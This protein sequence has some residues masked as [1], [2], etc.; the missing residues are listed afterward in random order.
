MKKVLCV[1]DSLTFGS[2]GYSYVRF[3]GGVEAV[4]RGLNGDCLLGMERRLRQILSSRLYKDI[5]LIVFWGGTNDVF[6]PALK[7][8]SCFW[9]ISNTLRPKLFGYRYCDTEEE[10]HAV[11]ERIIRLVLGENKKLLLM[12]LP[13]TE[14]G[15]VR[16]NSTLQA[17][18]RS[19]RELAEKYSLEF[20]DVYKL[21]D[22]MR[23]PDADAAYSWGS[24]NLMRIIDTLLMTV[25]PPTKRLFAK[26][27][28]LNLTVD[29]IHL[30][31]VSAKEI[32]RVVEA[33]I[34]GL[35]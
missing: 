26:I 33:C 21:L 35:P 8:V 11:Y 24:L 31:Q 12:G 23:F 6:L 28:R 15:N 2:V 7:E 29:G 32:G 27:R 22:E 18:N 20:I 13:K 3:L 16:V 19:I 30:S 9:R 10:F 17:R 1:G 5:E 14:L 34:C 4:N 25:C